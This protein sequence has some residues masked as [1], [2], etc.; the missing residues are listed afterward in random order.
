MPLVD[1]CLRDADAPKVLALEDLVG[2]LIEEGHKTLVFSQFVT[3]LDLLRYKAKQQGWPH[4]E[5]SDT[6]G[7]AASM[8]N[9]WRGFCRTAALARTLLSSA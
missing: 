9:D 6:G 2:P 7:R 1:R 8:R 4:F 3:L 5:N